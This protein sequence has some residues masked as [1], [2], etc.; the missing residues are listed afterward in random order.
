MPANDSSVTDEIEAP[1]SHATDTQRTMAERI[2]LQIPALALLGAALYIFYSL[3]IKYLDHQ[4]KMEEARTTTLV[5]AERERSDSI[6]DLASSNKAV[7]DSNDKVA[8]AIEADRQA[9]VRLIEV[10]AKADANGAKEHEAMMRQL[11]DQE[12]TRERRAQ[13]Y[14]GM[15]KT[16]A[17]LSLAIDKL[18]QFLS[19]YVPAS[20]PPPA[21][22]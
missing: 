3:G 18:M 22:E 17:G 11:D 15:S 5:L 13:V 1:M 7:A 2:M 20:P 4:H 12:V 19:R 21:R 6:K 16:S 10:I 9:T 8:A 14:E